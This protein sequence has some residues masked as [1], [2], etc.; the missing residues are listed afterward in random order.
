MAQISADQHD[1][2]I[3]AATMVAIRGYDAALERCTRYITGKIRDENPQ[4]FWEAV[5][6]EIV[7]AAWA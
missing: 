3:V 4:A 2:K 5:R 6:K 1:P 7:K